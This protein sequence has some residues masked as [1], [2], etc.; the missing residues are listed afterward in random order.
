MRPPVTSRLSLLV[1]LD[2]SGGSAGS[3]VVPVEEAALL[4]FPGQEVRV[5][6]SPSCWSLLLEGPASLWG[7][8]AHLPLEDTHLISL[9]L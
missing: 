5:T 7:F 6:G 4:P 8:L 1:H 2:G 9:L 3:H